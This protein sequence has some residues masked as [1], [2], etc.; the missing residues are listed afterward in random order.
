MSCDDVIAKFKRLA[1][2]EVPEEIADSIIDAIM[3]IE[4]MDSLAPLVELLSN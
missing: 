2:A 1:S 3:N 4:E